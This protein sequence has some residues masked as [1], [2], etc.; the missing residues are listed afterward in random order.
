MRAAWA[1][2]GFE[3]SLFRRVRSRRLLGDCCEAATWR[4]GFE[5]DLTW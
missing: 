3:E 2:L 5:Q 4:E 1:A